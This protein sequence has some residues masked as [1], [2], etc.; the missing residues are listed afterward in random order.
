MLDS[1]WHQYWANQT[2]YIH[3]CRTERGCNLFNDF[4]GKDYYDDLIAQELH[5]DFDVDDMNNSNNMYKVSRLEKV[6]QSF[7][8]FRDF[9]Y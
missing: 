8:A 5:Q 1:L 6:E 7:N 3:Y 2:T 4:F 9:S